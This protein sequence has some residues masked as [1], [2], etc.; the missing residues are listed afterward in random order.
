[1]SMS[2]NN[3]SGEPDIQRFRP[4]VEENDKVRV[5]RFIGLCKS[6]GECIA[7]CPAKCISWDE[8]EIGQ[9]GEPAIKIDLDKCIACETCEMI[10]PD[11]A[12]EIT[13]KEAADQPAEDK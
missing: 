8:S 9:V 3:L 2:D 11:A 4:K 10:C 13:K 5:T 12:I 7:K 1:M 6:C